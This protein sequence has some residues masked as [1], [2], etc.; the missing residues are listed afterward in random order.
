[1]PVKIEYNE[2]ATSAAWRDD[3]PAVPAPSRG[4]GRD[5]ITRADL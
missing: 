3:W 1:M 2:T 4:H 5:A